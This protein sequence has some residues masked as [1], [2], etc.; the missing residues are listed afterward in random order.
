MKKTK[1]NKK[2]IM[3]MMIKKKIFKNIFNELNHTHTHTQCQ[4]PTIFLCTDFIFYNN[5]IF[6]SILKLF[7]LKKD[8]IHNTSITNTTYIGNIRMQ[9]QKKD[10]NEATNDKRVLIFFISLILSFLG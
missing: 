9:Q 3:V 4:Q 10:E 5:K 8:M 6:Y 1:Q 7:P 2:I